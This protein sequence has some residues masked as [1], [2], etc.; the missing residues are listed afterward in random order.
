MA[1][2]SFLCSSLWSLHFSLYIKKNEC[3]RD[4][5]CYAVDWSLSHI[6]IRLSSKTNNQQ[7]ML[8]DDSLTISLWDVSVINEDSQVFH[9]RKM[10]YLILSNIFSRTCVHFE[11]DFRMRLN[12]M[13]YRKASLIIWSG[14]FRL[15]LRS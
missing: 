12:Q 13:S 7:L 6:L 5:Y 4:H 3:D 1:F 15:V 11:T 14:N 8:W 2:F 9:E 10:I